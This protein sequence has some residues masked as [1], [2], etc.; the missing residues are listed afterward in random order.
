MNGGTISG[1]AATSY[2]GGEV[3]VY[4][5]GIFTKQSDGT[6]YGSDASG[7]LKNTATLTGNNNGH[8]VYVE[9]SPLNVRNTTAGP[10]VILDSSVNGSAGG[11]E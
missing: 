10:G 3:F 9:T 4:P 2:Y 6:I 8:A 11:R 5:D 7:T 1:N